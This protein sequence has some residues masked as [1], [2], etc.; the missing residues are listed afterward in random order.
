MNFLLVQEI[1][2]Q[3]LCRT[4][5]H[6][7]WQGLL[8]AAVAGIIITAT[9]RSKA[10][11]RYNLLSAVF[12]AS[13]IISCITFLLQP[14]ILNQA[15]DAGKINQLISDHNN[16]IA[17]ISIENKWQ[18]AFNTNELYQYI[19]SYT[20]K[21]ASLITSAWLLFLI[22]H[23]LRMTAGIHYAYRI[24]FY[25]T[26]RPSV[27]WQNRLQEMT[28]LLNI[29]KPVLL[30]ESAIVKVPV[31]TGMLKPIVLVPIGMLSN[32]SSQ[33]VEAILLHELA[34]V[35]RN[36]FLINLI[37]RLAESFFFFN[38]FI[39]WISARIREEREACCDDIV[40]EYTTDQRS[41]FEALI[42]FREAGIINYSPAMSLGRNNKLLYRVKRMITRENK[43]LNA[44][45]KLTLILILTAATAVSFMPAGKDAGKQKSINNL[46]GIGGPQ[47][48]KSVALFVSESKS[49]KTAA[50]PDTLPGKQTITFSNISSANN[51]DG[52]KRSSI[53][54]AKASDGKTY[55][56]SIESDEL[57]NLTIDDV[58][59]KKEDFHLYKPVID[60]I[61]RARADR[62]RNI[63]L[64]QKIEAEQQMNKQELLNQKLI[65]Q[66]KNY[67]KSIL[68]KEQNEL[69]N[70]KLMMLELQNNNKQLALNDIRLQQ[71]DIDKKMLLLFKERNRLQHGEKNAADLKEQAENFLRNAQQNDELK[72]L[73]E[74]LEQEKNE[75]YMLRD[76]ERQE[77][78]EKKNEQ[79]LLASQIY[80]KKNELLLAQDQQFHNSNHELASILA[81]LAEA[82]VIDDKNNFSFSLDDKELIVDGKKQSV[83]LHEM[84]RKKYIKHKKD[85]YRYKAKPNSRSTDVYVE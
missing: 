85:Y 66:Q 6:S 38:P 60:Q 74:K 24:R 51:D 65:E 26:T 12:I 14:G 44:M 32:L 52:K 76:K 18:P 42:S 35:R 80:L 75:L 36:D 7:L 1:V 84:L 68:L 82:N 78:F 39:A 67:D 25:K 61:E 28:H 43:K 73:N 64:N 46:Q 20:D 16:V 13:I 15:T 40:M 63:F 31:V 23:L 30:L 48:K 37:Q 79:E 49:Q 4:L 54:T 71:A 3:A 58:K 21:Y 56:Y 72:R 41:Y 62:E 29:S 9:K 47:E 33:Q 45:E 57:I 17:P 77:L 69:L 53:V 70:D 11:I 19:L 10:A 2:I 22:V 55:S 83:S 27:K 8:A 59:I 5:V 50:L 81:D 34:H